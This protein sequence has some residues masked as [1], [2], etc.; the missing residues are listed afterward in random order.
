MSPK[1]VDI[2]NVFEHH[3]RLKAAPAPEPVKEPKRFATTDWHRD[4]DGNSLVPNQATQESVVA[5]KQAYEN[6]KNEV[7][8][9][10]DKSH[11]RRLL[12][13][14]F[15]EVRGGTKTLDPSFVVTEEHFKKCG[16]RLSVFKAMQADTERRALNDAEKA[17]SE[18]TANFSPAQIQQQWEGVGIELLTAENLPHNFYTY[19]GSAWNWEQ[20]ISCVRY[21]F[22]LQ[23]TD[24]PSLR[25][26]RTAYKECLDGGNLYMQENYPRS[27]AYIKYAVQGW[28]PLPATPAEVE[29]DLKNE[30]FTQLQNRVRAGYHDPQRKIYW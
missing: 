24:V 7:V 5:A 25:Q 8:T 3:N 1:H 28:S 23:D 17:Y 6:L 11:A 15:G 21:V 20:I 22:N 27:Q 18:L 9:E 10:Q 26:M 29:G 14:N 4:R 30:S 16:L 12:E 19:G 13:L 2:E